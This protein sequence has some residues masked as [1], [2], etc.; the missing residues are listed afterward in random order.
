M[1]GFV[2]KLGCSTI[3]CGE[4]SLER[5]LALL[6]EVGFQAV[7]LCARPG[8]A[9]HIELNQPSSYYAGISEQA[10]SA[11]LAIESIGGTGGT[12]LDSAEFDRLIDAAASVGARMIVDSTGG[13]SDDEAS[14]LRT[15]DKVNAAAAKCARA[16][17][18]IAVKPHAGHAIFSTATA[19]R[20]MKEVDRRTVALCFEASHFWRTPHREDPVEALRSLATHVRA[21]RIRDQWKSREKMGPLPTQIPGQGALDL[22]TLAKVIVEMVPAENVIVEL[23]GLHEGTGKSESDRCD[24]LRQCARELAVLFRSRQTKSRIGH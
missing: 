13:K 9:N 23:V 19:L 8:I 12:Q 5:S 6:A 14:F 15:V 22:S 1:S 20:L 16:G 18:V 7:E 11:G 21:L 3:V 24:I 17:I 10:R 2:K 4:M